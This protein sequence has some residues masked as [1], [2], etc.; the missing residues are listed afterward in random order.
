MLEAYIPAWPTQ[1]EDEYNYGW[2]MCES[3][4]LH[5]R[6]SDIEAGLHSYARE[7]VRA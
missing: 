2:A 4:Q 7:C 5:E 3:H 1:K 6:I